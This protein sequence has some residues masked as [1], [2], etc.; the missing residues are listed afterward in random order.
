MTT[1]KQ[2]KQAKKKRIGRPTK[3]P[4]PGERVPLGLRVTPEM[5]GRLEAAAQQNGRSLSQEAELRLERSLDIGRHLTVAWG[6]LWAP[7]LVHKGELLISLSSHPVPFGEPPTHLDY[8]VALEIGE[9]DARR[10]MNYF[11]GAPWP[12]THSNE[13]IDALGEYW[14]E[15]QEEIKRGK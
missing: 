7:V 15:M 13:E 4:A 8:V 6:D 12:Y 5:K 2:I 10:L 9:D 14:L 1:H 3:P 11:T